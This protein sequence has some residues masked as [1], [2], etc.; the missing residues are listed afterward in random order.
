MKLI[1]LTLLVIIAL[2]IFVA[3]AL[4]AIFIWIGSKFAGVP[5]A[6]FGKAFYAA[7]LSSVAVW[8][9][10]G[11]ATAFFG[12][13]SLAGWLLGIIVTLGILKSV[14]N[15]EWSSA[16]LVWIFTGVAHVIVGIVMVVL[17]ITGFLALAL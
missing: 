12:I 15:T 17:V 4:S 2:C 1:G 6:T 9:L 14:Y 8:A 7:L 5:N 11:A 16:L 10:T 3:T 13:G